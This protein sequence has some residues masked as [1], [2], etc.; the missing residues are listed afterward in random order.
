M[1]Y[2]L[3][4]WSPTGYQLRELEGEPPPV[5]QELEE[6]GKRLVVTKIGTS[7]L[8]SD[9]RACVYSVGS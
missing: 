3:F 4:V 5:G 7:P 1:S 9:P 2:L 6:D 8:P